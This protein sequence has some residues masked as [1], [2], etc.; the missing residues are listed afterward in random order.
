MTITELIQ[1]ATLLNAVLANQEISVSSRTGAAVEFE[2][3]LKA[4]RSRAV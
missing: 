1:Y 2:R 4:I 3:I